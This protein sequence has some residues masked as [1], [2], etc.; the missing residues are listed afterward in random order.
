M[1]CT[2]LVYLP[3]L[4]GLLFLRMLILCLTILIYWLGILVINLSCLVDGSMALN[5][6]LYLDLFTS[7][8]YLS[9]LMDSSM[10]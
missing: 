5:A 3:C 6:Y 4:W 9:C 7:L 8:V 10:F 2:G 1:T